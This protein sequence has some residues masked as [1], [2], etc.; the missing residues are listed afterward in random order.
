MYKACSTFKVISNEDGAVAITVYTGS[1][2]KHNLRI[3]NIPGFDDSKKDNGFVADLF[4]SCKSCEVEEISEICYVVK[5]NDSTL[6]KNEKNFFQKIPVLFGLRPVVVA[7]FCDA[8]EP[9]VSQALRAKNIA[10][11]RLFKFNNSH[12][13]QESSEQSDWDKGVSSFKIFLDYL[14]LRPPDS[15]TDVAFAK[16]ASKKWYK[17]KF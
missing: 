10:V 8:A 2:S 6:A 11:E 7:N 17:L 4:K 14:D 12:I 9:Q 1:K 5:S 13:F 16:D 3:V 15:D